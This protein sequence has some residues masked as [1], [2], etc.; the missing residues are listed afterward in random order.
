MEVALI[1]E[2]K[3]LLATKLEQGW[4]H[5]T[6]PPPYF[7]IFVL[8][9][10]QTGFGLVTILSSIYIWM[11]TIFFPPCCI[12]DLRINLRINLIFFRFFF[13]LALTPNKLKQFLKR[14]V[15]TNPKFNEVGILWKTQQ[16][17]NSQVICIALLQHLQ[18]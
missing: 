5:L 10:N 16:L 15:C 2:P 17:Y 7:A 1:G 11:V 12:F 14:L 13:F 18:P 6:L 9:P 3:I 4:E 8:P